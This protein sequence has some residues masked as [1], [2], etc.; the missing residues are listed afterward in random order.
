MYQTGCCRREALSECVFCVAS[1]YYLYFLLGAT[2]TV[3]VDVSRIPVWVVVLGKDG[4]WSLSQLESIAESF[5][6]HDFAS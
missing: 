5:W 4:F 3:S 1:Y 2:L 6:R